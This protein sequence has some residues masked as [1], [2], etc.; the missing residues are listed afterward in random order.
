MKDEPKLKPCPFCGLVMAHEPDNI[1]W[2]YY[3]PKCGNE[4]EIDGKTEWILE[5]TKKRKGATNAKAE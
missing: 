5:P 4:F 3:C 1:H 2:H